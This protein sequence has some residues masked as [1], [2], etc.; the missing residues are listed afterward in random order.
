MVSTFL[1]GITFWVVVGFSVVGTEVVVSGWFFV[2]VVVLG[3]FWVVVVESGCF[4]VVVEV[5]DFSV[6][7]VTV[8]VEVV[9]S[10]WFWVVVA[11]SLTGTIISFFVVVS[12]NSFKV[13]S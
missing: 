7:V 1:S 4:E 8:G 12:V 10:S 5:S 13:F 2:E 6:V 3:W 11:R 9:V